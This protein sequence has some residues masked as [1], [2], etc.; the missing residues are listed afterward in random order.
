M[1]PPDVRTRLWP[2]IGDLSESRQRR[3]IRGLDA[4]VSDL[5]QTGA[6]LFASEEGRRALLRVLDQEDDEDAG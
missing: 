1:L 6:T 4:V 2:F 3:A 5:L